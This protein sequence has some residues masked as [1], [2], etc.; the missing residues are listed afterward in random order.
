ME[1]ILNVTVDSLAIHAGIIDDAHGDLV[2]AERSQGLK[3]QV[4]YLVSLHSIYQHIEYSLWF[5]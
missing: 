1:S 3:W 5:S 4:S 2:D